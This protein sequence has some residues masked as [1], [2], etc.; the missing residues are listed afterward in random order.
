MPRYF[1]STKVGRATGFETTVRTVLLS[2]SRLRT[3]VEMHGVLQTAR[4]PMHQPVLVFG[5]LAGLLGIGAETWANY[6][7]GRNFVATAAVLL[8]PLSLLAYVIVVVLTMVGASNAV[9]L[10]DGMD[11]LAAG[12]T[13]I[14]S[15]V[16]ML[17]AEIVGVRAWARFA[18]MLG[19]AG[20]RSRARR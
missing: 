6:F 13:A 12:C 10:T 5:T 17:L 11:G 16:L 4:T 2:I 8:T 18:A 9:N 14:V 1:P 7:Y 3:L 15:L 19:S 20:A